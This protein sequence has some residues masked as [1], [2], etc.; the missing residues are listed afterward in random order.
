[1]NNPCLIVI[2]SSFTLWALS[3]TLLLTAYGLQLLCES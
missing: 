3:L 1:M 2:G